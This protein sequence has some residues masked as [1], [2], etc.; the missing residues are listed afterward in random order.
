MH[1]IKYLGVHGDQFTKKE[2]NETRIIWENWDDIA[3]WKPRT[4]KVIMARNFVNKI[5]ANVYLGAEVRAQ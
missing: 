4:D 1:N 2:P 3:P 5:E